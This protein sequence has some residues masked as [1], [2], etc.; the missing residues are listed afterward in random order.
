M[1]SKPW[2]TADVAAHYEVSERTVED[3][4]HKGTG[5]AFIRVGKHVRYLEEDIVAYE[6]SNRCEPT[7]AA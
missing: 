7:T 5:P 3:W 4:R 2:T 6:R 1:K